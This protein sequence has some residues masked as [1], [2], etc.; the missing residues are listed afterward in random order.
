MCSFGDLQT[1]EKDRVTGHRVGVQQRAHAQQKVP[2]QN[3]NPVHSSA[4]QGTAGTQL[5][6]PCG[7]GSGASSVSSAGSG[8]FTQICGSA[9][10]ARSPAPADIPGV[11]IT[12]DALL[13]ELAQQ[14]GLH[15]SNELPDVA[16]AAPRAP[17]PPLAELP[18]GF[19]QQIEFPADASKAHVQTP[20][21][22]ALPGFF[23]AAGNE[24]AAYGSG[25]SSLLP[26]AP[27][28]RIDELCGRFS[29]TESHNDEQPACV[30]EPSAGVPQAS[31]LP[32]AGHAAVC[33]QG[34]VCTVGSDVCAALES[35]SP[36]P[37]VTNL[38]CGFSKE[39]EGCLE[40]CNTPVPLGKLV[41]SWL[42]DDGCSTI[43]CLADTDADDVTGQLST[44]Q[45]PDEAKAD[46]AA[47]GAAVAAHKK[48][49]QHATSVSADASMFLE[50]RTRVALGWAAFD[51]A[52]R[53]SRSSSTLTTRTSAC[54]SYV[55]HG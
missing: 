42:S 24:R 21:V 44:H 45:G 51:A 28:P 15:I 46:G 12:Q 48:G 39:E 53:F 33:S 11:H 14:L 55:F 9:S 34:D 17:L 43:G 2:A 54:G 7:D 38:S 31:L 29:D 18:V 52:V 40:N 16:S 26:Q 30:E 41:P 49:M 32:V 19:S 47:A 20:P 10:R 8:S 3:D 4:G 35:V 23:S 36:P 6:L 25:F 5:P 13:H 27:L 50:E 37:P 22:G 1:I